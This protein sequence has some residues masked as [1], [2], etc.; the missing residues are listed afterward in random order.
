MQEDQLSGCHS[1]SGKKGCSERW[2]LSEE[3]KKILGE[4]IKRIW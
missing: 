1:G 2:R 3:L 4:R